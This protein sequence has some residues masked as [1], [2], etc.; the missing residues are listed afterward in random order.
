METNLT[1]MPVS[2][3]EK[4]VLDFD[5]WLGGVDADTRDTVQTYLNA[6]PESERG[7]KKQQLAA[8]FAVADETGIDLSTVN[9]RWDIV[10]SGFAEL[11]GGDWSESKYDDGKFF[12]QLQKRK[13]GERDERQLVF[14]PDEL[15]ATPDARPRSAGAPLFSLV[16]WYIPGGLTGQRPAVSEQEQKRV[17]FAEGHKNS[18]IGQAQAAAYSG[19]SYADALGEWQ[20]AVKGKPGWKAERSAYHES[21][22][23]AIHEQMTE[24]L[25]KVR[26]VAEQAFGAIAK[27]RGVEGV[28]PEVEAS[29]APFAL[30][31][32]MTPDEKELAF[33]VMR[34]KAG[35]G[36]DKGD[37]AGLM[38]ASGEALWRG[39]ENLAIGGS[40]AAFQSYLIRK[41]PFKAGEKVT[42]STA[43]EEAHTNF[44]AGFADDL[45]AQEGMLHTF[46]RETVGRALGGRVLTAEEA[47]A[48]NQELETAREDLE[49]AEQLREFGQQTIDPANKSGGTFRRKFWLPVMDS[50]A[51]MAAA[52]TGGWQGLSL[53]ARSYQGQEFRRLRSEGMDAKEADELAEIVGFSQAALDKLELGVLGKGAS[54]I[55]KA[56]SKIPL[57]NRI[58][59]KGIPGMAATQRALQ[60]HA[61]SGRAAARFGVNAAGTLA[62]ETTIELLQDH[63][64]PAIVQDNLASD[65]KFDV[66]WGD[67][68]RDV[69]AA[70]PDIA[71]GMVLLSGMGG[72]A[73]TR[74][75]SQHVRELSSSKAAMRA[76]GYSLEQIAE[77]QAAPLEDRGALLAEYLPMKAP[78]GEARTALV[79]EV[80]TLARQ[81][82]AVFVAQTGVDAAAATEAA[83]YAIRVVHGAGGWQVT[84]A[85]GATVTVDTTEAARR[86]REDLRQARTQEEAAA[87]VATVEG[88]TAKAPEG[89]ERET[90]FTGE[91]VLSD[92]Q[93]IT[94]AR[95]GEAVREVTSSEDLVALREEARMFSAV[96]GT[97]AVEFAVNG[98]N[99]WEFAEKVANGARGVI[100]RLEVNQSQSALFT[101]LHEAIESD[102][103][104]AIRKGA[105]TPAET[106]KAIASIAPA[107]DP[108]LAR[109]PEE[110]AF[111]ERIQKVASGEGSEVELRE[112]LSELAVADVLGRSRDGGIVPAGGVSAAMDAAMRDMTDAAAIREVGRIRAFLRTV[113]QYLRG[114]FGTVAALRKARRE[115]VGQDFEALI[116]KL[117]GTDE[118]AAY[119]RERAAEAEAL[120]RENELEYTPPTEEEMAAGIAFSLS[121][122]SPERDARP[123]APLEIPSTALPGDRSDWRQAVRNFI[124]ANLQGQSLQN[125]DTGWKIRFNADSKSESV[126]KLHHEPQL[127]AAMQVVP[128]VENAVLLGDV[129][130]KKSRESDTERF[131]YF[132]VPVSINGHS[133]VAWFNTRVPLQTPHPNEGGVFYEFGLYDKAARTSPGL[134]AALRQPDTPTFGPDETIGGFLDKIKGVLPAAIAVEQSPAFLLSAGAGLEAIQ[135]RLDAAIARDPEKRRELRRRASHNLQ[136]L[137]FEWETE[138]WTAQGDQ[139]RPLVDKRSAAELNKEQGVR[140]ALRADELMDAKMAKL[141]FETLAALDHGTERLE[142]RPLIHAM[143]G[144]HGKLI[145]KATA[146]RRGLFGEYDAAPWLPPKWYAGVG[147]GGLLPDQMAQ[148]LHDD[149]LLA[150]P[151]PDALWAALGREI[152]SVRAANAAFAEAAKTTR[153]IE[154]QARNQAKEEAAEWRREAGEM[155]KKDWSPKAR[156]VRHMR[157]LDAILS[158]MPPELRGKVGGFVKLATLG[159]DKARVEEIGRRIQKLSVLLEKHLQEEYREG[160]EAL[161]ENAAPKVGEN[162]V[163]KSTIGPEAQALVE[164]ASEAAAL[165]EDAAAKEIASL[166]GQ[167]AMPDLTA[168]QLSSIV[169]KWGVVNVF[170]NLEKRTAAELAEAH[171][172]LAEIIKTGRNKWRV[173][174][175]ARLAEVRADNQSVIARLGMAAQSLLS[176][177]AKKDRGVL[178]KLDALAT[179]HYAFHQLLRDVLGHDHP[180]AKK[181]ASAVR[182]ATAGHE[183][184]MIA[185][186]E[187]FRAALTSALGFEKLSIRARIAMDRALDRLRQ[188]VENAVELLEGRKTKEERVP[189]TTAEKVLAGEAE[190]GFTME[191]RNALQRALDELP[192]GHRKEF[193]TIERLIS[194]GVHGLVDMS[195]LEAMH[196]LLSWDQ[197]DVRARMERQGFSESAMGKMREMVSD[198]FAQAV[199]RHLRTEYAAGYD[200]LNPVYRRMFGMNMPQVKNYA[201]TAYRAGKETGG[202][203]S[204][205]GAAPNASGMSAGFVKSRVD[206]DA[207][208]RQADALVMFWQHTAQSSYWKNFAEVTRELRGVLGTADV[209]NSIEQA[210]GKGKKKQVQQWL[211]TIAAGGGN[212]TQGIEWVDRLM[213]RAAA[214]QAVAVLGLR[215]K[216]V[217]M[218]ADA[219][220]RFMLTLP[221]KAQVAGLARLMTGQLSGSI[222]ESWHSDTI[223]RRLEAGFT[224][225]VRLVTAE[226]NVRPSMLVLLAEKSTVPLQLADAALT[227]VSA[228]IVYD[229]HF[230]EGR[231]A[232]MSETAAASFAE[233]A[234][235][236]AV[237][238]TAQPASVAQRSLV[239]AGANTSSLMKAYLLFRSDARLKFSLEYEA[240]KSLWSEKGMTRGDAL[241]TLLVTRMYALLGQF[242]ADLFKDGFTGDDDDEIWKLE[243]YVR[244]FSLGHINGAFIVGDAVTLIADKLTTGSYFSSNQ[245]LLAEAGKNAAQTWE[246]PEDLIDT[247]DPERMLRAWKAA[248]RALA[249]AGQQFGAPAAL[250]NLLAD[251]VGAAE[252]AKSDE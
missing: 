216:T 145:S 95:V 225:E 32:G 41:K 105:I 233:D 178:A 238:E 157:T 34:D 121:P 199:M 171:E 173:Q 8:K 98:A 7:L 79:A 47:A 102:W 128:I 77:I 86:I 113:R 78:E 160:I 11:E 106:V 62:A 38:Q 244:A 37:W 26:P 235:D 198:D 155:Q 58:P 205:F 88:W 240:L 84:K 129:A 210:E 60:Q 162:R 25:A 241:R 206:H 81:E 230:R 172:W 164:M 190:L 213:T 136:K 214:G 135:K 55:G 33:R 156:L 39:F 49:T 176:K 184:D 53:N 43:F 65:P 197:L 243:N 89:V 187:R 100:Q 158:V 154:R 137:A 201:P 59:F 174:E 228:A 168:E 232:G 126:G 123:L 52:G 147:Q 169:E 13:M 150:D 71:L 83:D 6:V 31:R 139:I 138:R 249:V 207:M 117:T 250:V 153:E 14:G 219:A 76:R 146:A 64:I 99:T 3:S 56:A 202:E 170:G 35:D 132:A 134:D 237:F 165:D 125:R 131:R 82:Q 180:V 107:F 239:E 74:E 242:L 73:Q 221:V 236:Q 151:S 87:L 9:D 152:E 22:A 1:N 2:E 57:V 17:E 224:P 227:S 101:F 12:D 94:R 5:G 120:A 124:A 200:Q 118:Q 229:Y 51:I 194:Q 20:E 90:A 212:K 66:E 103:R 196:Y 111:R 70:A 188:P 46:F 186:T 220:L 248:T 69:A 177:R 189:I 116:E 93:T 27:A 222:P 40:L 218:Q 182:K 167:M 85:D 50:A 21:I 159:T 246:H 179:S 215:T 4:I 231:A 115:G 208:F 36:P 130:P 143:L 204:P 61:L 144:N 203:V 91:K 119:D 226:A 15:S 54:Y 141:S 44:R 247:D 29:L 183:R 211:D 148:N 16:P 112:T 185:A 96:N 122:S 24:A 192:D 252:N 63:V 245:N 251:V 223:Q 234:M 75:Q 163:K 110:R 191:D 48:W 45:G 104:Q 193:V 140:Q 108:E 209:M 19:K 166:E 114:V 217:L 18:L 28:A 30:L 42:E 127:R 133:A 92:G 175:E 10:R 161:F 67:V 23:R 80:E 195:P 109:N 142:D 72:I 68:W 149:G 181:L 97:E